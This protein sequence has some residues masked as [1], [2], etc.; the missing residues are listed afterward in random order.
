MRHPLVRQGS[1]TESFGGGK[2]G[3]AAV[4]VTLLLAAGCGAQESESR[5]AGDKAQPRSPAQASTPL[6]YAQVSLLRFGTPRALVVRRIGPPLR[7]QKVKPYGVVAQCFR[8]GAIYESTGQT[9]PRVE[10]R[11]C[12]DRRDRL[13]LKSTAP[14]G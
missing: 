13:S 2:C 6:G 1:F 3:A 10:Y 5:G 7:Q 14:P 12:Y 8:Y 9:D 11:L 4:L